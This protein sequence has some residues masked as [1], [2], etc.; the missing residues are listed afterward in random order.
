[1]ILGYLFSMDA[2]HIGLAWMDGD[3]TSASRGYLAAVTADGT[4]EVQAQPGSYAEGERLLLAGRADLL[5]A[6][7]PGF[8]ANL[9]AGRTADAAVIADGTDGIFASQALGNLAA[10][11]SAYAAGAAGSLLPMQIRTRSWY[12]G[13][14][15]SLWSM[16]PGLIAVVL[17][18]PTLALTL[19]VG[20]E[21]ETGTLE[22]L[23]ATPVRGAEYQ[24]GKIHGLSSRQRRE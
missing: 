24:L 6:V 1:L 15:R 9:L 3:R 13:D 11:T 17:V 4:F 5:L 20:R 19:A 16:V 7:A 8:E 18:L 21:R 12:N 2:N 22:V 14:L 23:I 10:R